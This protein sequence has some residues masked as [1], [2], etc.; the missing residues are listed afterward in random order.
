VRILDP[1]TLA[2]LGR[3]ELAAEPRPGR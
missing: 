2:D 1:A 3:L